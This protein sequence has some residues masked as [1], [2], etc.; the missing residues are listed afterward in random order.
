M[1]AL[2]PSRMESAVFMVWV[3]VVIPAPLD[4]SGR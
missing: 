1:Q 3:L 4:L 2:T